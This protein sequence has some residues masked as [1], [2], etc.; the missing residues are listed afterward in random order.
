MEIYIDKIQKNLTGDDA[1]VEMLSK[2]IEKHESLQTALKS[3]NEV[4]VYDSDTNTMYTLDIDNDNI[5][6]AKIEKSTDKPKSADALVLEDNFCH[7]G[8]ALERTKDL[9]VPDSLYHDNFRE[10]KRSKRCGCAQCGAIFD[11][12]DV[13]DMAASMGGRDGMSFCPYCGSNTVV[14]EDSGVEIND[15]NLWRWYKHTFSDMPMYK[16][17][18]EDMSKLTLADVMR[19]LR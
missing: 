5:T 7:H 18:P 9:V 15:D 14:A 11:G 6:I 1:A 17:L 4:T 8:D 10:S 2:R 13:K 12:S 19:R 3:Q 16:D